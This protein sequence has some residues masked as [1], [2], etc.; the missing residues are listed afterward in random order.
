MC[1]DVKGFSLTCQIKMS[2]NAVILFALSMNAPTA[3]RLTKLVR[4]QNRP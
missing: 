2:L 1:V 4:A 3:P